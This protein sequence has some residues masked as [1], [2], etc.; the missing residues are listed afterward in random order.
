MLAFLILVFPSRI[1]LFKKKC[2]IIIYFAFIICSC[3]FLFFW[4]PI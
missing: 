4:Y 1:I 3:K 2:M